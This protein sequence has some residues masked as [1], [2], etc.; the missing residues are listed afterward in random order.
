MQ[1]IK[2]LCFKDLH[3]SKIIWSWGEEGRIENGVQGENHKN[4]RQKALVP[5]D[6]P[7]MP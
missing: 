5:T 1:E 7:N 4:C 6:V 3:V 2:I